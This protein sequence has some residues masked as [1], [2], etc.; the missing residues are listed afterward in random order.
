MILSASAAEILDASRP[1]ADRR[2]QANA[3]E[4]PEDDDSTRMIRRNPIS[5]MFRNA[6][7]PRAEPANQLDES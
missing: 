3:S 1:L 6:T 2:N 5:L 4:A 7:M